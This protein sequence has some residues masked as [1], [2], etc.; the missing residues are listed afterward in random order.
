MAE[1]AR[2]VEAGVVE[3]VGIGGVVVGSGVVEPRVME[4]GGVVV[5]TGAEGSNRAS[6]ERVQDERRRTQKAI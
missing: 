3:A 6:V 4:E 1:G 5:G 2:A